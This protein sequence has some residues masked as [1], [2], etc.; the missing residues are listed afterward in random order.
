MFEQPFCARMEK[1]VRM[2]KK[3]LAKL[4]KENIL[5]Y[6][7]QHGLWR[8]KRGRRLSVILPYPYIRMSPDKAFKAAKEMLSGERSKRAKIAIRRQMFLTGQ[9][10]LEAFLGVRPPMEQ[11]WPGARRVPHTTNWY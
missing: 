1:T 4:K 5:Q 10:P 8:L 2:S 7:V 3:E 6:V 11:P 9:T